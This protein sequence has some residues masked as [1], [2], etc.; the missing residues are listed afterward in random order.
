M[1]RHKCKLCMRGFSNG[2]ALGGHMR[3]HMM[4]LPIHQN[5]EGE[6]EEEAPHDQMLIDEIDSVSASF[7]DD[8]DDDDEE[9]QG[10]GEEE[11]EEDEEGLYYGLRENPKRSIRLVDH[12]FS[13][14][15]DAGSVVLQ[16]RES[17]TE[18]SKNP[19]RRR[20]KRTR[21]SAMF[22]HHHDHD[23]HQQHQHQHQ[24]HNQYH[25]HHPKLNQHHLEAFKKIKL[26]NKIDS[27]ANNVEPEPV[28]SISDATTEEDVAFCLMMLSR[29]KWKK[30]DKQQ[31][32]QDEDAEVELYRSLDDSDE[33]EEQLIKFQKTKSSRGKYKCE[34][35]KKVFKSYQALGG[36]RAS[37]KKIKAAAAA[38]ANPNPN[39]IVYEPEPDPKINHNAGS[40]SF[41]KT[42]Q[43][44]VCF[45]VFS[46]GQALGGH[47]RSHVTGSAAI[48]NTH[49]HTPPVKSLAKLGD[50]MIDLNL[51]APVDD[52]EMSQIEISA[53]S[54]A[55]FVNPIR[56]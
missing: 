9:E 10:E 30:Q 33:S 35:C 39:R 20:S 26:K 56:R 27:C 42:H 2:R 47:K 18:S 3:S 13:F 12:E 49:H 54:D 25:Q 37:H 52:D 5:P 28:S 31:E 36:H 34:T 14:A 53:V 15:V 23:D 38:A 29:D 19:T 41:A 4:N 55:E 46:S 16:D 8:D 50:N 32:D 21:K 7:S 22:D 44:P 51:P 48:N 43:C 24:L 1:E 6:E 40:S 45:R 11:E 17:E